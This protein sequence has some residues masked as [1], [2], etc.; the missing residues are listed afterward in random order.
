MTH[1]SKIET[2]ESKIHQLQAILNC[3]AGK[4]LLKNKL[5]IVIAHD[6]LYFTAVYKLIREAEKA[7]G[8]WTDECEEAFQDATLFD[9]DSMSDVP[10]LIGEIVRLQAIVD[11]FDKTAD[12]VTPTIGMELWYLDPFGNILWFKVRSIREHHVQGHN[13]WEL[14][15]VTAN[16]YSTVAAAEAAK[17]E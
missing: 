6:E 4:L 16:C 2:L 17:G 12:G 13:V 1:F 8:R 15:Y 5:F 7:D 14:Y 10:F 11:T 3:R 9:D